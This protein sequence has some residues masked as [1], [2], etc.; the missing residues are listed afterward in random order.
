MLPMDKLADALVFAVAHLNLREDEE[1]L[2][3]DMEAMESIIGILSEAT[4]A[5]QDALAAAAKRAHAR[6]VDDPEGT[7]FA[8]TYASWMEDAFGE[9]WQGNDRMV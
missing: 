5:E 1:H 7:E 4:D 2:D 9:E 3:E 8:E 6:W